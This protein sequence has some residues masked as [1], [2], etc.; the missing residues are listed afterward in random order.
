[1]FT[2]FDMFAVIAAV[3]GLS[4]AAFAGYAF[5][6]GWGGLGGAIIGVVVG[7]FV[8]NIPAVYASNKLKRELKQTPDDELKARLVSQY[9]ISHLI[10]AE[11]VVRGHPVEDFRDYVL[12]RINSEHIDQRRFAW[13]NLRIWF[14]ELAENLK[15]FDPTEATELCQEKLTAAGLAKLAVQKS[16]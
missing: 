4:G 11:L 15:G 13:T 3:V 12:T 8:G 10:I 7:W 1:M 6:G 14:P 9:Y 16:E 2:L 5:W